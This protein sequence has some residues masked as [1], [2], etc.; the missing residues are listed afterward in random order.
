[1][2]GNEGQIQA[3]LAWENIG[4]ASYESHDFEQSSS[5]IFSYETWSNSLFFKELLQIIM[6]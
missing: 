5:P 1:M 2:R 6:S 4:S 3:E